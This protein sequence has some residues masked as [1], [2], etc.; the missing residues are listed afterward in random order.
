M[1][2]RYTDRSQFGKL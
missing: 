2:D 1:D